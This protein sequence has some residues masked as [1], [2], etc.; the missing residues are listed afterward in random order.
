MNATRLLVALLA[1][2]LPLSS[3]AQGVPRTPAPEDAVVYIISPANGETVTSPVTVRF[4]LAGMGVAPAGIDQQ[5]TGHH[6]LLIDADDDSMPP[7]DQPLPATGHVRHFGGGQTQVTLALE[8]GEHSLQLLLGDH[9][10][11]PHDPP[12]ISERITIRVE[13]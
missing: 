6:H 3:A 10:H 2:T 8:P 12:V 1:C 13:E 5:G 7:M 11:I 4:G 9:L